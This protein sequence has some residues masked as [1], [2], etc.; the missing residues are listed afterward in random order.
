MMKIVA[1]LVV[2]CGISAGYSVPMR[3]AFMYYQQPMGY[4][5]QRQAMYGL[6]YQNQQLRNQRRSAGVSALAAGTYLKD[7][8]SA[9]TP[10]QDPNVQSVADAYPAEQYPVEDV[11]LQDVPA[12]NEFEAEEPI[13]DEPVAAPAVPAVIPEKKKKKVTVQLDSDEEEDTQVSRRGGSR[14]AAPNAYFPIN[15]GSTNGGAIAIANSYSTGKGGSATST[16]TAYGSPATAELRR[17]AP[18]QLRKK[19][20]KLR[21][22]Q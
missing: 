22:R 18:A 12:V 13:A 19:P 15:F 3:N 9:E 20:A 16:A 10:V 17:A 4:M 1:V 6:H 2:L 21:A 5:A 8:E 7:V 11:P 14:P